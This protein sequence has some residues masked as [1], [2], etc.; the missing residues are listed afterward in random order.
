M[1]DKDDNYLIK[2]ENAIQEKYG[3]E[4][5]QNPKATW[6]EE[7][8]KEYLEQIKKI[9]KQEKPKEKIEIDG[10]LMPKKLFRKESKRT[11]PVCKTYSFS[12][13]DDLYMVKFNH[14]FGCWLKK[15]EKE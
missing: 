1:K 13:R 12:S 7:K 10:V 3:E 6:D 15:K 2:V 8:E 14:C 11:C 4:T 9:A 5:I